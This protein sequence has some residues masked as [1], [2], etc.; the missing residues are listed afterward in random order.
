V[1]FCTHDLNPNLTRVEPNLGV[2]FVFHLWVHLKPEK[3]L[4]L[5]RNPKKLEKNSKPERNKKT[6]KETHLQNPTG[7]RTHRN[8]TGSGSG[9]KF[10]LRVRVSIQSDYI[11]SRIRFLINPT[12]Y[13]PYS[14]PFPR[15]DT[16]ESYHL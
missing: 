4:K 10:H 8:P 5:E 6:M 16:R 3:N 12:R 13:H 7:T 2:S 1:Y 14:Q 9:A 11:F 15:T